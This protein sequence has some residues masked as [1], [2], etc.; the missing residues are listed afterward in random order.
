MTAD[1]PGTKSHFRMTLAVQ[2]IPYSKTGQRPSWLYRHYAE[3][4][5]TETVHTVLKLC[6]RPMVTVTAAA[7]LRLLFAKYCS[8][9]TNGLP[10]TSAKRTFFV[11]ERG[12]NSV[13]CL[14]FLTSDVRVSCL[15]VQF[16]EHWTSAS[17]LCC[18]AVA[19]A[20]TVN[21]SAAGVSL[22]FVRCE[23]FRQV[24]LLPQVNN[25][26]SVHDLYRD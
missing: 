5:S 26:G 9:V 23:K 21:A 14:R 22:Q 4:V 1:L 13:V 16:A 20:V 10:A 25:E 19:D 18:S 2:H 11:C 8:M 6:S 12:G 17:W 24:T 3:N 7:V 15:A